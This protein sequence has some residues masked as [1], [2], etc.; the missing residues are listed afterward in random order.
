LANY[1]GLE[2]KEILSQLPPDPQHYEPWENPP[3]DLQGWAGYIR[4]NQEIQ[5]LV[6]L[7]KNIKHP[8]GP[9]G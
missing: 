6:D 3:E 2:E 5:K 1:L 8:N 7:V 9:S 4:N